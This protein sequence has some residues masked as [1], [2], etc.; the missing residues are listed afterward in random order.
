MRMNGLLKRFPVGHTA[1]VVAVVGLFAGMDVARAQVTTDTS[2]LDSFAPAAPQKQEAAPSTRKE[3]HPAQ[4]RRQ[5]YQA[6]GEQKSPTQAAAIPPPAAVKH[7]PPAAT[8]PQ[9]PPPVPVLTP[10]PVQVEIHPFPMPADPVAVKDAVGTVRP[11]EGGLRLTFAPDKA[12]LNTE[13]RNGVLA[14]ARM[15]KEN[16][17]VHGLVDV[18]ASGVPND[19]S[20]P[21][22][23]AL[24]RGLAVRAVLM[25]DGIPSTRIYVRVIGLP[26]KTGILTPAD[27]AD[28]R[29]SDTAQQTP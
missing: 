29:R 20:R 19:P 18:T 21:R 12:D 13:T 24:Q 16:P 14:F 28:L 9:A 3:S 17:D 11:I 23:V 15:L 25:N 22:R 27:R 6:R 5:P 4:S 10:P 2:V 8:I 26:D 1:R 7:A